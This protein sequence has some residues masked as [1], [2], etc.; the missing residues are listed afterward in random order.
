MAETPARNH[1]HKTATGRH[2][3]RKHQADL[4]A[5][6]AAGV[7]VEHRASQL[8]TAPFEH[9]AR[10]AH[11]LGQCHPFGHGHALKKH[12][13]GERGGLAFAPGVAHQTLYKV[14]NLF[15]AEGV[16]VAFGADDFLGEHGWC[17]GQ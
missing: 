11:G 1:G 10:V 17:W 5:H 14:A 7:F 12:R 15:G 6:T 13:H 3:G 8:G 9:F 2:H 16:A 4:V